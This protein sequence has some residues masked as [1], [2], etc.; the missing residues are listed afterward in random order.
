[1]LKRIAAVLCLFLAAACSGAGPASEPPSA[2]APASGAAPSQ[3]TPADRPA[4]TPAGGGSHGYL[5]TQGATIVDSTGAAVRL[6]GLSWFGLETPNYALHGLWSRSMGDMLD[7]VKAL[8]YNTIR[9]P[10]SNQL[11]DAGSTPNSIDY[12]K[13]PDLAGLDG[14][15]ILDKLVEG[16][17]AR[18]LRII[19]DRHRPDSGAQSEL[20][21]TAQYSEDR[22][23]ADWK[24][25]AARYKGDPTV[26]GCDLHNEPHGAATW[27]DGN[28]ATDWRLAAER[29]GNAILS[30]NPDL[31]IF[32][33]GVERLANG[34]TWWGGNLAAAGDAPVRLDVARRVVYSPH[35]YPASIFA[36]MWFADPT[37]PANLP[38]VWDTHWGYL[39]R[40]GIA[41]VWIGEWGTKDQTSSDQQWF[42]TLA[43]YIGQHGLSFAF[44]SLNPDS[45]DTGGILADDWTTVNTE[46]QQVVQP[47]LAPAL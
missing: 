20:W 28:V 38:D 24:M 11:F 17:G 22:W 30:V 7:T 23:I 2:A 4:G 46:K 33:E 15:H 3:P 40:N 14:L 27:G 18:G 12:A 6:T 36:Q 44:W 39:V 47:L 43:T 29:A 1:M 8:G 21:Y 19:L 31:L 5:H 45:G 35:D 37:Y 25:L 41:P 26:I 16:A 9:V 10:Y 34:T 42:H 32:V 13:N